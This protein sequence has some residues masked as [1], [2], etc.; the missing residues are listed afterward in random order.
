MTAGFIYLFRDV[1]ILTIGGLFGV[2]IVG[3]IV[4]TI[5]RMLAPADGEIT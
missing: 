4:R 1:I 5:R 3:R 2:V